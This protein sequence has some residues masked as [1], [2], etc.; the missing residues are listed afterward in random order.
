MRVKVD[1][2]SMRELAADDTGSA[3]M[4]LG[5]LARVIS[6]IAQPNAANLIV[7]TR[8]S[9]ANFSSFEF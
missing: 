6:D 7:C 4:A 5:Q 3:M 9:Q 1:A 2:A 8:S